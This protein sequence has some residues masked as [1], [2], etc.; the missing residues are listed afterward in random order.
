MRRGWLLLLV[1]MW[2]VQSQA[3]APTLPYELFD[4]AWSPQGNVIA[5]PTTEGVWLFDPTDLQAPP[6]S[7]PQPAAAVAFNADG[8]L[9][10]VGGFQAEV[11]V[12]DV[13]DLGRGPIVLWQVEP[14]DPADPSRVVSVTLSQ[15]GKEG[16]FIAASTS[17]N[18][19]AVYDFDNDEVVWSADD[20]NFAD[21]VRFSGDSKDL[22]CGN[23]RL[24]VDLRDTLNG[25]V[26][27]DWELEALS[28]RRIS[29]LAFNAEGDRLLIAGDSRRVLALDAYFGEAGYVWEAAG[30][31]VRLVDWSA[32]DTLI[33]LV[34][35]SLIDPN[36]NIV[37]LFE[38][39]NNGG[40]VGRLVGH[41]APIVGFA[42]SP[43]STQA[44]TLSEDGDLRLWD[45]MSGEVV[46]QVI[47]RKSS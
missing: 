11:T 9:L 32:D 33:G 45:V 24:S 34:N 31:E 26:H 3:Q 28:L 14:F 19:L 16:T 1:M 18:V 36:L 39:E 42:F 44:V 23:G 46:G 38:A 7:L 22:A 5:V 27:T 43:D 10:A 40:E 8:N 21:V 41:T 13:R 20:G 29:D 15:G 30:E 25:K 4:L 35:Y 2:A 47:V 12:F 17:R 37:Q 6:L